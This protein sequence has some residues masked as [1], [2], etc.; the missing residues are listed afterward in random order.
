VD[1]ERGRRSATGSVE[2]LMEAY[3]DGSVDA[4][5]ELY[6]RV[7][8]NI[9]AYLIRLTRHRERAED[10]LQITFTKVHRARESYLRGAPLLPWMLAIARRSFLDER[11]S[12]SSRSEDLSSDGN[13]PEPK[14]QE[15]AVPADL[16]DALERALDALP[17][18]YREAIQLTK[19][20]GLSIAEA[21]EVLGTSETAVKLRVHR[22]YTQLR[23]QLEGFNRHA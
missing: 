2:E 23:K 10:L 20:S 9:L 15:A 12:A 13:L 22:G 4:F 1:A 5:D 16:S 7:A 3:V 21:A 19:V 14:A 17:E 8:P 18:S 11:R 6:R